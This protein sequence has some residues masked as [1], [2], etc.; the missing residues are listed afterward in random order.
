MRI[1]QSIS[2]VQADCFLTFGYSLV[3]ILIINRREREL[4]RELPI[5]FPFLRSQKEIGKRGKVSSE[6]EVSFGGV[7]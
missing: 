5:V 7:C 1:W 3:V 4:E 6:P 2:H